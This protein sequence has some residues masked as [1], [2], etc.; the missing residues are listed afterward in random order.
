MYTVKSGYNQLRRAETKLATNEASTS[1]QKP[2]ELWCKIWNMRTIPKIKVFMWTLCQNA[3]PTSE[4][5]R[6]RKIAPEA[7]CQLCKKDPETEEHLFLLCPRSSNP[8]ASRS[9]PLVHVESKKRSHLQEE[10]ARP[11]RNRLGSHSKT[12]RIQRLEPKTGRARTEGPH[13][14]DKLEPTD[15]EISENQC[16]WRSSSR[17]DQ[18]SDRWC[19]QGCEWRS[20]RRVR[21]PS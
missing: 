5:L 11:A 9:T 1:Y 15:A 18:R 6:R 8:R 16:R 4:N 21:T 10:N 2:R 19:M 17:R 20:A 3:L 12:E 7:T 14:C 13:L